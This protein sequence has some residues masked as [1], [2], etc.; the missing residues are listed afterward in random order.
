METIGTKQGQPTGRYKSPEIGFCKVVLWGGAT[1]SRFCGW[2]PR[3]E[4]TKLASIFTEKLPFAQLQCHHLSSIP[5]TQCSCGPHGGNETQPAWEGIKCPKYMCLVVEGKVWWLLTVESSTTCVCMHVF[6][7]ITSYTSCVSPQSYIIFTGHL[8]II[9]KFSVCWTYLRGLE[10]RGDH[11]VDIFWCFK[12]IFLSIQNPP[13]PHQDPCGVSPGVVN[14][15][16]FD[17]ERTPIAG[18]KKGSKCWQMCSPR[19]EIF[20]RRRGSRGD[21]YVFFPW[22]LS[23]HKKQHFENSKMLR[24]NIS[25]SKAKQ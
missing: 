7:Y 16:S 23:C 10:F 12:T 11:H 19:L 4:S 17:D 22:S 3:H 18:C 14:M 25:K 24:S 8:D 20:W 6:K 1:F 2:I 5:L 15:A 9:D 21:L 13:P